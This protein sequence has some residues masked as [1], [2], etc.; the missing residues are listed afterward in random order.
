MNTIPSMP[1]RWFDYY[2]LE[3]D[4]ELTQLLKEHFGTVQRSVLFVLARSFDPRTTLGLQ[5]L[6]AAG[7]EGRR[8]VRLLVYKEEDRPDNQE[9]MHRA[10]QNFEEI[11]SL[12]KGKGELNEY[13]VEFYS[14]GRRVASQ[15]AA[16]TF[17]RISEIEPY[18][19]IV[20]DVSG[21]PRGVY[22]PLV[23]RLLY[24]IDEEWNTSERDI[25]N[26]FLLVAEDPDLDAAI[27]QQGIEEFADFLA[28]FRGA[29]GQEA[30]AN[31]PTHNPASHCRDRHSAQS[32]LRPR[33]A[34]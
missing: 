11:T 14:D 16:D 19:D 27:T 31:L 22:F 7:G 34:R 1:R 10:Q 24:F 30:Q 32:H 20:V 6:I 17:S 9:L 25:P 26:L 3:R 28:M 8:D 2:F 5:M 21:M 33:Q 23:A 15:R 4:S 13:L 29:F 18:T 12:I